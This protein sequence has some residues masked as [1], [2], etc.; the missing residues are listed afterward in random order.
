MT[1]TTAP[2]PHGHQG[3]DVEVPHLEVDE[4]VPPRP[5]EEIADVARQ[6]PRRSGAPTGP[7]L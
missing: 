3:S 5:E 7:E 2:D 1:Q 4:T 6:E